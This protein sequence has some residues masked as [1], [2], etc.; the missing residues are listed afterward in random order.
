MREPKFAMTYPCYFLLTEEG[1]PESL[2]SEGDRCICLFTDR[3]LAES[4]YKAKY[5][6]NFAI[7]RIQ[8]IVCRSEEPLINNLREWQKKLSAQKVFHLAID[9]TPRKLVARVLISE[10]IK[11]IEHR[12]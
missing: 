8:V 1:N 2:V 3:D 4:W 6:D 10:F 9:A 11:E 12:S 7:Q 5:G